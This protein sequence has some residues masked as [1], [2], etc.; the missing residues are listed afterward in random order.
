MKIFSFKITYMEGTSLVVQWLRI[1]TSNAGNTG[2]YSWF[3]N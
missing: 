1:C 3:G 2:F